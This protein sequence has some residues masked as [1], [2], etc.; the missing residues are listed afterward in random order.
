LLESS[1]LHDQGDDARL[2]TLVEGYFKHERVGEV[3]RFRDDAPSPIDA[4]GQDVN[5]AEEI[6]LA[7]GTL[8][9]PDRRVRRARNGWLAPCRN[10][11]QQEPKKTG[12]PSQSGHGPSTRY[13]SAPSNAGT[14]DGPTR[15]ATPTTT[16]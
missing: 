8:Y 5:R 13:P 10:R 9:V 2:R 7:C 6:D 12:K 1:A 3:D 11:S 15:W 16:K 14:P 4:G